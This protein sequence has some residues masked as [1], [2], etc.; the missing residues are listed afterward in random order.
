MPVSKQGQAHVAITGP[1]DDIPKSRM[2][3]PLVRFCESRGSVSSPSY[4]TFYIMSNEVDEVI[5]A[6]YRSSYV[7]LRLKD[8]LSIIYESLWAGPVQPSSPDDS[9]AGL[10]LQS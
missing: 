6:S 5:S 7:E 10:Q 4:S 1:H 9:K 2:C 3:G 8:I